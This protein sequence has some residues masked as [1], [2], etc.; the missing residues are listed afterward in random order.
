MCLS[1]GQYAKQ[2]NNT[3]FFNLRHFNFLKLWSHSKLK[4]IVGLSKEE[5][6]YKHTIQIKRFPIH[7][8]NL[9]TVIWSVVREKCR[10][11]CLKVL[12]SDNFNIFPAVEIRKSL[13]LTLISY[14]YMMRQSFEKTVV[15]RVFPYLQIPLPSNSL[16]FIFPYLHIYFCLSKFSSLLCTSFKR[17]CRI[18]VS[19]RKK[20]FNKPFIF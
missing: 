3:N 14:W 9:E 15:N 5:L 17:N 16:S 18:F 12:N 1:A 13:L 8:G 20:T 10:F 19:V 7:N 6:S 4:N 11:L 2:K